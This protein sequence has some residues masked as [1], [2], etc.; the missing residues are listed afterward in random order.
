MKFEDKKNKKDL[1]NFVI[2]NIVK[3]FLEN[4]EK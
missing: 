2:E 4:A 1:E 3:N